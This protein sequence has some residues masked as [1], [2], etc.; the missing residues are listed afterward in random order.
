MLSL[1]FHRST[2]FQDRQWL[3]TILT[4]PPQQRVIL[5][6]H[7]WKRLY[8]PHMAFVFQYCKLGSTFLWPGVQG[9][10]LK[11][12]VRNSPFENLANIE[13]IYGSPTEFSYSNNGI[14]CTDHRYD[15][16]IFPS[17]K[18]LLG[19][20]LNLW[21]DSRHLNTDHE[22][23]H[24]W[25]RVSSYEDVLKFEWQKRLNVPVSF[26]SAPYTRFWPVEVFKKKFIDK[27]IGKLPCISL[28]N[29]KKV[30]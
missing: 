5:L 23:V 27:P 3:S 29:L 2:T 18:S 8:F 9:C 19:T 20:I 4:M 1:R 22:I 16:K 14:C 13:G 24:M 25:G 17:I 30:I 6:N 11:V 28:Q 7:Q 10:S 26:Y 15:Y 12:L 21:W